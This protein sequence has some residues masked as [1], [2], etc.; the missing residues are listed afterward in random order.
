MVMG[1]IHTCVRESV[2]EWGTAQPA[3]TSLPVLLLWA[4]YVETLS[5]RSLVNRIGFHFGRSAN[6]Q[7]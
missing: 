7:F 5:Q 3:T 6:N 1:Q 4:Q 2:C